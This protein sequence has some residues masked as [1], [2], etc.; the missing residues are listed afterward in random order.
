MNNTKMKKLTA[1]AVSAVMAASMVGFVGASAKFSTASA[2]TITAVAEDGTIG[3]GESNQ[4]AD[5]TITDATPATLDL[6]GVS[7]GRYVVYLYVT[8]S[9][10]DWQYIISAQLNNGTPVDFVMDQNIYKQTEDY[11][12]Y[13][14][15]VAAIDVTDGSNSLTLS[16]RH[17][18]EES[19]EDISL[20][21][22]TYLT[23]FTVVGT[24]HL[25]GIPVS[26][27][28]PA[29]LALSNVTAGKYVLHA[30]PLQTSVEELE[31]LELYAQLGNG[32]RIALPYTASAG[33]YTAVVDVTNQTS[34]VLSTVAG[35]SCILDV[36]FVPYEITPPDLSLA[37][38]RLSSTNSAV[39][40][41]RNVTAAEYIVNVD[42][43]YIELADTV[44]VSAQVTEGE[45]VPLTKDN[46]Y[47]SAYTG[48]V[49]VTDGNGT[50]TITT[51]NTEE[52]TVTVTLT[53]VLH[54]E[55]LPTTPVTLHEYDSVLYEYK[56]TNSGY[57]VISATTAVEKAGFDILLKED[58][59]SFDSIEIHGN[60]F[61][62]YL[63]ANK[64]YYYQITYTGVNDPEAQIP[65]ESPEYVSVQF[66]VSSWTKPVIAPEQ[67]YYV[68]V[69]TTTA[70]NHVDLTFNANVSGEY[71]LSLFDIPMFMAMMGE[72][73]YLHYGSG[74]P[75]AL[76]SENGYSTNITIPAGEGETATRT[77][78]LTT[79]WST[80]VTLG[81]ILTPATPVGST[82]LNLFNA[83]RIT[84]ASGEAKTYLLENIGAGEYT[85][86]L[87]NINNPAILVESST[88]DTA[89]IAA[90]GLSGNFILD[91]ADYSPVSTVALILT[92]KGTEDAEFDITVSPLNTAKVGT[93]QQLTLRV[94]HAYS[95]YMELAA[96]AYQVAL[97]NVPEGKEV[98]VYA[99]GVQVELDANNTG[100]IPV[101]QSGQVCVSYIYYDEAE[102]LD[103]LVTIDITATV[104]GVNTLLPGNTIVSLSTE[105]NSKTYYFVGE[106]G[107][108]T[109]YILS[110]PTNVSIKSGEQTVI[111][112]GTGFGTLTIAP[113]EGQTYFAIPLDILYNG[114][115]QVD[116]T[117]YIVKTA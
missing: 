111:N 96:G 54:Y 82:N 83:N 103:S 94:N 99:N 110:D 85:V 22:T 90:G 74:E 16:V 24:N 69:T 27:T 68:P 20:T 117:I 76:N 45:S 14:M 38:V 28:A 80:E 11:Q 70:A 79:T 36:N 106:A 53:E 47:I 88:S 50:L 64:T 3:I 17:R 92:N 23:P 84:L 55:E 71:T 37:G 77:F 8:Q 15:Y 2:S 51:S 95:N 5:V 26:E 43:G 13:Y 108:Y 115:S 10:G 18:Y 1:M 91:I 42:F 56:V 102:G 105:E 21:V 72:T 97:G 93:E 109:I 33:A 112:Y 4:A 62:T 114:D 59:E 63:V 89:V 73:V 67:N 116:V 57:Y 31:D 30:A 29:T 104:T 60:D 107:T 34:L 25:G 32:S 44:T 81:L 86:T 87:S 19:E 39:I 40:P 100:V 48:N 9:S 12:F 35:A 101:G 6:S 49:T 7:A 75:I 65:P 61:P 46:N 41:L 58:P 52:L 66:K 113:V 78:Y 98:R